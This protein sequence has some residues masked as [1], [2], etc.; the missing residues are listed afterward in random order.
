MHQ[1]GPSIINLLYL[2]TLCIS[3]HFKQ[4]RRRLIM[5]VIQRTS[6]RGCNSAWVESCTR[7]AQLQSTCSSLGLIQQVI[8]PVQ[9]ALTL[10]EFFTD[11]ND[12]FFSFS[13]CRN[14]V[15][16]MKP[17]LF[18]NSRKLLQVLEAINHFNRGRVC[19]FLGQSSS[20]AGSYL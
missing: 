19:V 4:R 17:R 8:K 2:A 5:M 3:K 13:F 14:L 9:C 12:S 7:P 1:E 15:R 6:L 18:G 11:I 10:L 20:T 16:Y